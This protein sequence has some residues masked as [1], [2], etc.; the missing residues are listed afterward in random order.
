LTENSP[1]RLTRTP[2]AGLL[3]SLLFR[4]SAKQIGSRRLSL[5]CAVLQQKVFEP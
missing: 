4:G 1:Q 3:R 2:G 5:N